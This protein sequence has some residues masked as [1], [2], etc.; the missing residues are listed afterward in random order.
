MEKLPYELNFEIFKFFNNNNLLDLNLTEKK[1]Y[2]IVKLINNKIKIDRLDEF[3][4]RLRTKEWNE[5]LIKKYV[6]FKL[7]Y[8]IKA[9]QDNQVIF[10]AKINIIEKIWNIYDDNYKLAYLR[11]K[12]ENSIL[13]HKDG[14]IWCKFFVRHGFASPMKITFYNINDKKYQNPVID[15]N[16]KFYKNNRPITENK[17]FKLKFDHININKASIKNCSFKCIENKNFLEHGKNI[18]N[19]YYLYYRYPLHG[20]LAFACC[21]VIHLA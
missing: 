16:E 20:L 7:P 4:W 13:Y 3:N 15:L 11:I 17:T 8:K 21:L 19:N 18:T 6:R 14:T 2:N 1:N 12:N 10:R 5:L 9:I